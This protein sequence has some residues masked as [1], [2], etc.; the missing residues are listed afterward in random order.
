MI[1]S[2]HGEVNRF[3]VQA[4]L[5]GGHICTILTVE[6]FV[7]MRT[8]FG[9]IALSFGCSL[10]RLW[11]LLGSVLSAHVV[12]CKVFF[13]SSTNTDTHRSDFYYVLQQ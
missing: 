8:L 12:I 7:T 9:S 5:L 13:P 4:N 2:H 1:F 6:V 10:W 11:S 3:V